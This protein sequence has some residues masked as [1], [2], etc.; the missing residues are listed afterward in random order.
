MERLT[1]LHLNTE[2][3]WRGGEQQMSYLAR[4]LA[5]RGHACHVVCR[6][7]SECER[8]MTEA[9]LPVHPIAIHGDLDVPAARR[10]AKLA[11]RIG[12][13]VLHAHTSRTHLAAVWARRMMRRPARCV[14]HR[15]VDFSIHKLPFRL[16]G[17]KYRRGVD[18]Y[19]AVTEAVKRVM[20]SDGL[21]ADLISVVPSGVDLS[22]FDDAPPA[23]DLRGELGVPE[24]ARVV[25]NVG[26]LVDH[27]DHHNLLD[28]AAL[29]LKEEPMAFFV[30]VGEGSLRAALE[31]HADALGVGDRARFVGFRSDVPQ[32]LRGFDAF[33][34]SSWGEGIGGVVLEA[35][36]ARRP[37]ATTSAGGLD[38]VVRNGENGL[39]VPTRNPKALAEALLNLL[40]QPEEAQR[41]AEAG[42]RTVEEGFTVGHMIE[43]TLAVYE[44]A[45]RAGTK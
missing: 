45:Q 11:D 30:I 1:V 31:A 35:M 33:C 43:R 3:G 5:E 26:A 40:R 12:A 16:S 38:E 15:R 18:R 9:G 21:D 7:D 14:V 32:C 25:G 13:D 8:R 39:L 28:A 37:V 20:V 24:G 23:P 10:I 41:L 6:P 36:A 42:R 4:G 27:K 19:I 17:L 34:L 2:R 22:R 29:V 44:E